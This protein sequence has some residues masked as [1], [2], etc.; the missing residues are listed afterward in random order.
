MA[1]WLL[2]CGLLELCTA[3]RPKLGSLELEEINDD[4]AQCLRRDNL[5][6]A[7]GDETHYILRDYY[8]PV[9]ANPQNDIY[10]LCEDLEIASLNADL[11]IRRVERNEF[12]FELGGDLPGENVRGRGVKGDTVGS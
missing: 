10:F 2:A 12:E 1:L 5:D 8:S 7:G 3:V 6:I 9:P 11:Q 4:R